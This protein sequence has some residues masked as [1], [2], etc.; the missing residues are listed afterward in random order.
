MAQLSTP[1]PGTDCM[2]TLWRVFYLGESP[3]QFSA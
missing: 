1:R 2:E 3:V